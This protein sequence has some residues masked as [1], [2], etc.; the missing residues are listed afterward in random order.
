M[1]WRLS[2]HV[3]AVVLMVLAGAAQATALLD[4]SA[5][6]SRSVAFSGD[7]LKVENSF[8]FER[9]MGDE[10]AAVHAVGRIQRVDGPAK[11][12]NFDFDHRI[13]SGFHFYFPFLDLHLIDPR[14]HALHELIELIKG[15]GGEASPPTGKV[16]E[17]API[18]LFAFA[19]GALGLM[20][21]RKPAPVK[22]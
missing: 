16:P 13:G 12:F 7:V 10:V 2:K 3:G 21:R 6:H 22:R 11:T 20:V 1:L 18:L 8:D 9:W 19:L 5:W 4:N 15:R 14:H 17:P